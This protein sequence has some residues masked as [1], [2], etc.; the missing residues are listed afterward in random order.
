MSWLGKAVEKRIERVVAEE[1]ENVLDVL[2]IPIDRSKKDRLWNKCHPLGG[3][4]GD[5]KAEA[6]APST[7][8]RPV[9]GVGA[10]V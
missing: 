4:G 10:G 5:E 1:I 9:T 8:R 7:K 6:R 2:F 3:L